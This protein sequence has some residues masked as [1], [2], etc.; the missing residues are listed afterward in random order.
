MLQPKAV[1]EEQEEE[2]EDHRVV[3]L[4]F[5]QRAHHAMV[6]LGWLREQQLQEQ[7]RE[8]QLEWLGGEGGDITT[9][10]KTGCR[11][12]TAQMKA[13]TAT[14]HGPLVLKPSLQA[15]PSL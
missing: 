14:G 9:V 2:P 12:V 15:L 10:Q 8:Q 4:E 1:E 13:A 7:W 6:H 5:V 11:G 3:V